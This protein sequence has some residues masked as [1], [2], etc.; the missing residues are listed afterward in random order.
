MIELQESDYCFG[1]MDTLTIKPKDPYKEVNPAMVIAFIE[2][3]LGYRLI[4][5]TGCHWMYNRSESLL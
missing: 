1:V 2:G 5:T 4:H 3:I